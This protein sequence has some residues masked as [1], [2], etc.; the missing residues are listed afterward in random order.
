MNVLQTGFFHADLGPRNVMEHYPQFWKSDS[1]DN[2]LMPGCNLELEGGMGTEKSP[3]GNDSIDAVR[4]DDDEEVISSFASYSQNA[5]DT[6]SNDMTNRGPGS[7]IHPRPG[8]CC[9]KDGSLMPLGPKVEFKIIDYGASYFSETLAQA[10]GG[11]RS[12]KNYE[13]MK[14]MFLAKEL[15]FLS[16]RR[17]PGEKNRKHI[18]SLKTTAGADNVKDSR[19]YRCIPAS[20][21]RLFKKSDSREIETHNARFTTIPSGS[22]DS[23]PT[24]PH[25]MQSFSLDHIPLDP[26]DEQSERLRTTESM[27][28]QVENYAETNEELEPPPEPR[29]GLIERLYRKFWRRKGDVYHILLN[30]C[31]LLDNRVWPKED[32]MDVNLF[33]SLVYQVTGV[34]MKAA[35]ARESEPKAAGLFGRMGCFGT[36]S[37]FPAYGSRGDNFCS[38]LRKA[39][40]QLKAHLHPYNSGISAGQA[41]MSPFFDVEGQLSS[42]IASTV[43]PIEISNAFPRCKAP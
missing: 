18:V 1:A 34:K 22:C 13:R 39:R 30:L 14:R 31:I 4:N 28:Q 43:G 11:Y 35:F 25:R 38:R 17:N 15:A 41:L 29:Q 5:F 40:S 23:A 33:L 7:T 10:T 36:A 6:V 24:T 8:F 16:A 37:Q 3:L 27:V 26:I 32:E 12:R 20:V 42:S 9:N 19:R 21:K 2:S